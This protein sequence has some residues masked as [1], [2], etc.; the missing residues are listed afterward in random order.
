MV[1]LIIDEISFIG[2]ALFAKM[3]LRTQQAKRGYFS[4]RG[5]DPNKSSFGDLSMLLVGDFG[6]LEPI[7]D[8]SMCDTEASWMS[9]PEKLKH[10][11]RY[12]HP[13]RLLLSEFKEAI[14]LKR[15]HRSKEDLWWTESCLR[16]RDGT[17]TK[18]NDYDYWCQHD[19]DRGQHLKANQRAYFENK[20]L[21]LSL[22][23][24]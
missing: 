18:E 19:L 6:Q 7:D 13:G 12:H 17:C 16:L 23:H 10:R 14:M 1:L 9:C 22:I 4:E 5:I 15:I 3:H 11:W 20:A 24:I 8:W 2:T 21:W